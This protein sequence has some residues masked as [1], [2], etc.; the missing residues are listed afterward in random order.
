MDCERFN[1]SSDQEVFSKA[2][3]DVQEITGVARVLLMP[4]VGPCAVITFAPATGRNWKAVSLRDVSLD[5]RRT[6]MLR[7]AG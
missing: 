7:A 5:W 3:R 2:L 6:V 1:R 4:V